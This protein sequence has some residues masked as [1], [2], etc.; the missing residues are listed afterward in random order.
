CEAQSGPKGPA[1]TFVSRPSAE[2]ENG[3]WPRVEHIGYVEEQLAP[4]G[5]VSQIDAGLEPEV[6]TRRDRIVV[7]VGRGGE[8]VVVVPAADAGHV[9]HYAEVVD[10]VA[11][12][13]V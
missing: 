8:G 4:A 10:P 7:D 11:E 5:I 6:R 13:G 9:G 12:H 3:R 1:H 2:D